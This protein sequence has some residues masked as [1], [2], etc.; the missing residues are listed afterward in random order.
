MSVG[1]STFSTFPR[2]AI[3]S[4]LGVP[5]VKYSRSPSLVPL[6]VLP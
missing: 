5:V 6:F 3:T 2:F 1:R 4:R